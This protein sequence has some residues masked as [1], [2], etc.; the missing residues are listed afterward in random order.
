MFAGDLRF[1]AQAPAVGGEARQRTDR[2][3]AEAQ[4]QGMD[5]RGRAGNAIEA[6]DGE[7]DQAGQQFGHQDRFGNLDGV[8]NGEVVS[9]AVAQPEGGEGE[10]RKRKG[11][12]PVDRDGPKA[13]GGENVG[14]ANRQSQVRGKRCPSDVEHRPFDAPRTARRRQRCRHGTPIPRCESCRNLCWKELKMQAST[15]GSKKFN[16][17]G[18]KL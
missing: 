1:T 8:M 17:R 11:D 10:Q 18:A 13:V 3:E 2:D 12:Q 16:H 6:G 7:E 15:M 14:I 5:D 4:H 9:H